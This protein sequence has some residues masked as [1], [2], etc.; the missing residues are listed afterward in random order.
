LDFYIDGIRLSDEFLITPELSEELII[1]A[2]TMQS[3]ACVAVFS[4]KSAISLYNNRI[5][6][7]PQST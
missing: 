2:A 5:T 6:T 4:Q 3:G 7:R 1:G